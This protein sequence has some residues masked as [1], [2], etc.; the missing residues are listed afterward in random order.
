MSRFLSA[1]AVLAMAA[2]GPAV[3]TAKKPDA[4][5]SPRAKQFRA[6]LAPV[7]ADMAAYS[8]V[9]GK[10][11]LVDNKKRDSVSLQMRNLAKPGTTYTWSVRKVAGDAAQPCDAATPSEAVT[12]FKY[13]KLRA[14]ES[15]NGNSGAKS[16]TFRADPDARYVVHVVNADGFTEACGVYKA[17]SKKSKKGSSKK[18]HGG[19]HEGAHKKPFAAPAPAKGRGRD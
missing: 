10:S 5:P 3:A 12:G 7:A 6:T 17:K 14:N 15:G 8:A 9:K 1:V 11:Q 2:A 4:K 16:K 18:K 19:S 13:R